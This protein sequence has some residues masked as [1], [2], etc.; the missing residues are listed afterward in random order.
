MRIHYIVIAAAMLAAS[1]SLAQT[2][3]ETKTSQASS[4]ATASVVGDTIYNPA[5]T[6]QRLVT[7]NSGIGPGLTA[8]GVHS[9]AGSASVGV[10]VTGFNLGAG[11]TY[12]MIECNRRAYAASLAGMGQNL[13]AL[14]LL[15]QNAEVKASLNNTGVVCPHQQAAIAAAQQQR[16]AEVAAYEASQ[17]WRGSAGER[18]IP[19]DST[20]RQIIRTGSVRYA[21]AGGAA[22]GRNPC[23]GSSTTDMIECGKLSSLR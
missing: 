18:V 14:D 7:T 3:A 21:S 12:E 2:A 17:S 1:P 6:K 22:G 5:K 23:H 19:L 10:G 16:Q 11:A 9:C 4:G 15:C 13:A 8:A 20:G